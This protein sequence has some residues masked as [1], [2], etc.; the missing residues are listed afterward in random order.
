MAISEKEPEIKSKDDVT[1]YYLWLLNLSKS[2]QDDIYFISHYLNSKCEYINNI[3]DLDI[4]K[5]E[6][7]YITKYISLMDYKEFLQTPYWKIISEY[8]KVQAKNKCQLCNKEGLLHTHHRTY[9]IRGNEINNLDDLI[10]L[11]DKCHAKH[12]NKEIK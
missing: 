2:L 12:H 5:R 9:E 1:A 6:S 8:K 10:V 11:C 3:H 4:L 7:L